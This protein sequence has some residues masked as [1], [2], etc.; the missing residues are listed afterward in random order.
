MRLDHL[1]SKD[2]SKVDAKGLRRMIFDGGPKHP[3]ASKAIRK[4][5]DALSG[6]WSN[7][8]VFRDGVEL[9]YDILYSVLNGL[10]GVIHSIMYIENRIEKQ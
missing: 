2:I 6:S 9:T 4:S 1:L 5:R 8:T 10:L 7:G 3:D